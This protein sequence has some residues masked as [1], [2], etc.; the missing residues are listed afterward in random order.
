VWPN[1]RDGSAVTRN[2]FSGKDKIVLSASIIVKH[3][4]TN[5]NLLEEEM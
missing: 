2:L 3:F 5:E 1:Q 4:A